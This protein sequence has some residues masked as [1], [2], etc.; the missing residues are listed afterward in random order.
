VVIKLFFEISDLYIYI[1]E[2]LKI[3]GIME[4]A[5]IQKIGGK[6]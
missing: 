6:P 3:N 1:F 5:K 4:D 2:N